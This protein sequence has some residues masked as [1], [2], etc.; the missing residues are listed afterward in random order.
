MDDF[1]LE[2]VPEL[3]KLEKGILAS[4]LSAAFVTLCFIALY[5]LAGIFL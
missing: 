1:D 4:L 2:D 3:T 5:F